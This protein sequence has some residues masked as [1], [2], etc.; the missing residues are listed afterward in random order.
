MRIHV[1][2]DLHL[3]ILQQRFPNYLHV[4]H[5][6]APWAELLVL[7]GDIHS[8]IEAIH[9]F[10]R[11]PHPVVYVPGNHEYFGHNV[12]R[13]NAELEI[14]A[15]D[16]SVIVL[17]RR[18][19]IYLGTRFLGCTLW[20]DYRISGA[21]Q[22]AWSMA[23]CESHLVDHVKIRGADASGASFTAQSALTLHSQDRQWLADKLAESF[24]G[25]TVVVTHHG[26]HRGS[27]H[28]K[29][30]DNPTNPGF[31]SDLTELVGLADLWI[32]GHVHNS[33]D[34]RVG[35]CRVL[36]NPGSYP[37]GL[38]KARSPDDLTWENPEFDPQLVV[39]LSVAPSP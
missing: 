22:Q 6:F 25:P 30:Q 15:Q 5:L 27:I 23:V 8:G 38:R 7:A 33:F 19:W 20:T 39:E 29:Y 2:S 9:A 36:T 35:R 32:H 12:A 28:E 26:P 14:A 3:E 4:G 1:A 34:Y 21:S 13:L 31:V 11:W 18:E 24:D 10:G 16:T 17:N 37:V